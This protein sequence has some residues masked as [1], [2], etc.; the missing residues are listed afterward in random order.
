MASDKAFYSW[1]GLMATNYLGSEEEW[2]NIDIGYGNADLFNSDKF[3]FKDNFV[4]Y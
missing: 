1:D 2:N 3:Y 4:L